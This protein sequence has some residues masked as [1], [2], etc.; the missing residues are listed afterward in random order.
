MT[1]AEYVATLTALTVT[2][3]TKRYSAPPSQLSTAQL[4][5]MWARLPSGTVEVVAMD[6]GAG[7]PSFT[8]D[9][10]IAIEAMAQSTQPANYAKGIA[11]IDALQAALTTEALEGVLDSWAL[12]LD[13]EAI[14]DTAY[15]VI[16]ATVTGSN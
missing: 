8:C 4:P 14:G 15:W 6:G 16:V 3:V 13:A 1:Y 12:R 7:L 11:V 9:L 2:G 10:V 5:A